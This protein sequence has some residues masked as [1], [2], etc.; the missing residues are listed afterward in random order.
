MKGQSVFA[1]NTTKREKEEE[2][3]RSAQ[4]PTLQRNYATKTLRTA[5]GS[6]LDTFS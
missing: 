4:D 1:D 6:L 2:D 3:L 5:Y